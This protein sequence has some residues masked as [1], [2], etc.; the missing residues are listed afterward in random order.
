MELQ[1]L[2]ATI[3]IG[4][5]LDARFSR[6]FCYLVQVCAPNLMSPTH[7]FRCALG[8]VLRFQ[9]APELS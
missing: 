6:K 1:H 7:P 3:R 4:Q 8:A 5:Y 9:K 2:W